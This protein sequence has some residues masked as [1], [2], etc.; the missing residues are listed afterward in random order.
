MSN[1][2]RPMTEAE[3]RADMLKT[4]GGQAETNPALQKVPPAFQRFFQGMAG[5]NKS[6]EG[7]IDL[8]GGGARP[9]ELKVLLAEGW[10]GKSPLPSNIAEIREKQK[11]MA[12]ASKE[13]LLQKMEQQG[14]LSIADDLEINDFA[15]ASPAQQQSIQD[16]VNAANSNKFPKIIDTRNVP[17]RPAAAQ[18]P[19]PPPAAKPL[20]EKIGVPGVT[21]NTVASLMAQAAAKAEPVP[22]KVE[23]AGAPPEPVTEAMKP[24]VCP[25]CSLAL[26]KPYIVQPTDEDIR[27]RILSIMSVVR[28]GDGRF[29]KTYSMYG[30]Q[31]IITFRE[32]KD[33]GSIIYNDEAKITLSDDPDKKTLQNMYRMDRINF[34]RHCCSI[35]RIVLGGERVFDL[36]TLDE[37]IKQCGGD[38]GKALSDLEVVVRTLVYP[39]E[40]IL[41]AAG[42]PWAQF[43]ELLT[44]LYL[45]QNFYNG[46]A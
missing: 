41:M 24:H 38:A 43:E 6:Q 35:E 18:P 27:N 34:R 2:L 19:P 1:E 10:D 20:P 31:V 32:L 30:G 40:S 5:K 26:D 13:A 25:R 14:S 16:M 7:V 8:S 39:S 29:R 23:E 11:S 4:L 9:E 3:I 17:L 45:N 15:D 28:G 44:A 22:E 46:T 37:W 36:P 33:E 21:K 42:T 12:G